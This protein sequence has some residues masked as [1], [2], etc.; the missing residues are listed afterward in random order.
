M[1]RVA[2]SKTNQSA[3]GGLASVASTSDAAFSAASSLTGPGSGSGGVLSLMR[4]RSPASSRMMRGG[5]SRRSSFPNGNGSTDRRRKLSSRDLLAL[6]LSSHEY[7]LRYLSRLFQVGRDLIRQV[8]RSPN[9]RCPICREQRPFA[10]GAVLRSEKDPKRIFLWICG[11]C[12][13]AECA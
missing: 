5:S 4:R 10:K 3:T 1:R 13:K 8:T 6:K 11:D 9:L 2:P 12:I 7:S